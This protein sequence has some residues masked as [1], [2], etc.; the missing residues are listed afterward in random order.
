MLL[1]A[2]RGVLLVLLSAVRTTADLACLPRH[3]AP[4][5]ALAF[6]VGMLAVAQH[7]C[8]SHRPLAHLV[9]SMPN[10]GKHVNNVV[11]LDNAAVHHAEEEMTRFILEAQNRKCK[12]EFLPPYSPE[13]NPV[14][15]V[16]ICCIP[17]VACAALQ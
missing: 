10:V 8:R 3:M 11:V 7:S 17:L 14:R 16:V 1:R 9:W 6:V 4:L 15:S 13:L 2:V 12:L 5:C